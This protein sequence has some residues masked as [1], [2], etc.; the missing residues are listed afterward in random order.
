MEHLIDF[1]EFFLHIDKHLDALVANYG[2]Y[3]YWILFLII[4]CET[5]LVIT[6]I[7]PGDSLLFAAGATIASTGRLDVNLMALLLIVAAIGGDAL[8]YFFGH[9]F[10]EK[11]FAKYPKIFRPAYLEKT[12]A[13]YDKYGGMTIIYARFVPIVRTFAPFLAGV[14]TMKYSRFLMFNVVGAVAWICLF[15]YLGLFFGSIPAVKKNFTF[16]ILGIIVLSVLPP[17]FEYFKERR[18]VKEA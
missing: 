13:F 10:G 9:L 15:L 4:F 11:A 3:A 7:L 12:Q 17:F 2:T 1:A 18:K 5:G 14:G 16:V 8:N 6:P